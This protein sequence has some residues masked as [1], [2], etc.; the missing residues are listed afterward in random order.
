LR[1]IYDDSTDYIVLPEDIGSRFHAYPGKKLIFN[2]NLYYG[3][4]TLDGDKTP[5]YPYLHPDVVGVFTVSAHNTEHIKYAYPNLEVIKVRLGID[6]ERFAYRRLSRKQMQIAV[7]PKAPLHVST[8]YHILRSRAEEGLN[9]FAKCNWVIIKDMSEEDVSRILQESLM[10]VFLNV[11]EG[12]GRLPLEAMACGCLI[13]AY[14]AAPLREYLNPSYQ[15]DYGDLI[16]IAQYLEAI[17]NS[18]PDNLEQWEREITRGLLTTQAYSTEQQ[19]I[20]VIEAWDKI[21]QE[22]K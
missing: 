15:F 6:L 20:S 2:K 1:I 8:L 16:S 7:A 14:G 13:A 11:T 5:D 4:N 10:F 3:F 12:L 9:R 22:R 19:E 18:F 17:M 21:L